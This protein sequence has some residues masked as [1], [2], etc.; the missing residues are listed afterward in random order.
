MIPPLLSVT[1]RL[2]SIQGMLNIGSFTGK[3]WKMV[4]RNSVRKNT[5]NLKNFPRYIKQLI[6]NFENVLILK[7]QDIAIFAAKV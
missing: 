4:P 2:R 7:I 3:T 5:E 1:Q 6:A